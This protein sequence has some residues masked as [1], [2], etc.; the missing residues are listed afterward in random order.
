V[1]TDIYNIESKTKNQKG[2][3]VRKYL[4]IVKINKLIK[5]IPYQFKWGGEVFEKAKT[6]IQ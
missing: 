6:F 3:R 1:E 2:K 5:C 4:R